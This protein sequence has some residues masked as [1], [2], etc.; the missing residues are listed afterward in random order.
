[1]SSESKGPEARCWECNTPIAGFERE[2]RR[3]YFCGRPV[4]LKHT[5]YFPVKRQGL[6]TIYRQVVKVCRKCI[7]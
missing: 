6:Y 3:C 2:L 1:M 5:H 7:P 4:C